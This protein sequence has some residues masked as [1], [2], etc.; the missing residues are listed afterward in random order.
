MRVLAVHNSYQQRGGEDESFEAEVTLLESQGVEVRRYCRHNDEIGHRAGARTAIETIWSERSYREV[1]SIL[2]EFRPHVM[3]C[4]N[5]FPLIS[6]SVYYAARGQGVA[7]VQRLSNYRHFC[8]DSGLLYQAQPCRLCQKKT[9]AWPGV[10]RR[11]YRNS[12]S[13]STVVATSFALHRLLRTWSTKVDQ[14]I[15]L[16]EST[17]REYQAAGYS[18]EQISVVANFVAPDPG[19]GP[20]RGGYAIFVGRLTESKGIGTLLEAW[21][22]L[23]LDLKVV[24]QGP[25]LKDVQKASEQNPRIQVLGFVPRAETT[26]L[27]KEALCVVVPSLAAETFGR[28]VAEGF[29]V[30]TPAIC[31]RVGALQELV[32]H[33][34][35]GLLFEPGD[36]L[37]LRRL[38]TDMRQLDE[39]EKSQM[40]SSARAEFENHYTAESTL[41]SL[42][43]VYDRALAR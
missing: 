18:A 42:M 4:Y 21:R 24:G 8:L 40:R 6:P 34:R 20:G 9:I 17:R 19:V 31:S 26:T 29:S 30:G 3:H 28:V 15:A 37:G 12:R 11:C 41:K 32:K 27:M 2:R 1:L 7:V 38:V 16:S 10:L 35:T 5:I 13:A 39:L 22:E 25:L 33:G 43:T 14:Y 36:S 23:P